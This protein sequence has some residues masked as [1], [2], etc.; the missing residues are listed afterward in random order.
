[1][2]G[3]KLKSFNYDH[4]ATIFKKFIDLPHEKTLMDSTMDSI[5]ITEGDTK[6]ENYDTKFIETINNNLDK[7]IKIDGYLQSHLYFNEYYDDLINLFEIDKKSLEYIKNKYPIL[8][9]ENVVCISVHIRMG[10][11]GYVDYKFDYFKESMKY[12]TNK[13]PNKKIC[14]MILSNDFNS[15]KDWFTNSNNNYMFINDNP[16]YID[17]WIST[18]CSH[19]IISHST[20]AWW[21]AYLNKNKNK[22]VIYPNDAL[23]IY[24]GKLY[25]KIIDPSRR[26]E[27]YM[28]NWLC[29]NIDTLIAR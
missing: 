4:M 1:M 26:I 7:N 16:D 15:I 6:C 17:L 12:F 24:C 8:F 9:D 3:E 14:F 19:N 25:D 28:S 27:H 20:F 13:F 2:Y 22:I 29:F 23:K 11:A 21:G 5:T 10:W 18:L